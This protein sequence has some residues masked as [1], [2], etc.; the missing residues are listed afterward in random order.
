MFQ[1][2]QNKWKV[3]AGRLL[4]II[5]TFAIGGSL[6]GYLGRKLIALTNVEK[7]VGWVLLYLLMV[8]FLWPFCVILI[9][10]PMGQFRFFKEY[11][12]K[13]YERMSGNNNMKENN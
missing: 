4:L 11:L 8:T 2:L 7:G 10:I 9:S 1:K 13:M 3:S 5:A 6:C 12:K